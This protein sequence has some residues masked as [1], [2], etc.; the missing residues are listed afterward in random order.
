VTVSTRVEG[1]CATAFEPLRDLLASHLADGTDLGASVAVVHDGELVVDLWGGEA[2]PGVPWE[3]DTVVMV[4][5]VS[6]P[7]AALTT[8]VLADRGE[9]DLD[10]P[11]AS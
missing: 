4:W 2:R 11:V 7:M 6:K 10:A 3:E 9:I 1:V 8:L 5:S